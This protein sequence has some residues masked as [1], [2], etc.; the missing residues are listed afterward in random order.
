MKIPALLAGTL[1]VLLAC[2]A[3]GRAATTGV[4][5]QISAKSPA[6]WKIAVHNARNLEQATGTPGRRIEIV[7]LGRAIGM[8]LRNSPVARNLE[9]LH[10]SG[11]VVEAGKAAVRRAGLK[12]AALLPF[13]RYIR[14]TV[15]EIVRRERQGWAYVQP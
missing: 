7:V 6:S 11:V 15:A 10:A 3:P 14:S 5:F 1:V 2:P 12:A 4:V 9:A 8:L 13:V